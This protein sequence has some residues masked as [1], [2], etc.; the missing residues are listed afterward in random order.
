MVQIIRKATLPSPAE[1]PEP[2]RSAAADAATIPLR[3]PRPVGFPLLFSADLE[4]IEPAVAFLHEHAVQRAHTAD[5]LRTYAEILYDWFETLEQN[6]IAWIDADAADLVA[7]RNRMLKEASTH[8]QRPYS[9][10]TINHRVRGVLRFYEWAVRRGWLRASSVIGRANDF[11][12]ASGARVARAAGQDDADSKLFV[13]R[14]FASLPRPLTTAQARELLAAL[15]PPYD[16][17]ARWQL[18][19]GL[20]V[21]ELLRLTVEDICKSTMAKAAAPESMYQVID[22]LRKGRKNGY[23]I[24]SASLLEETA[25]YVATHRRAWLTRL[26]RRR[27]AVE[28]PALF[29]SS[30]GTPVSK[31]RYQQVIHRA[32]LACGFRATTHLLRATFACMLLARLERL[33]REGVAINPLLI[34]KVLMGHE[35]IETTDRYLRAIA[36]DTC[37][38]GEVLDSLS[39]GARV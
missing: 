3:E 30:R 20:R 27:G 28:T 4:L 12:I 23:V 34:V 1:V 5:T 7:Y 25:G 32:A 13:L 26:T 24:A 6:G 10:R 38:L 14:Q 39:A 36:V 9:I 37:L 17:M 16:L 29:I 22:V 33:A 19:T 18:Y 15:V 35:H 8:T 31:N 11:A 2:L 21:S